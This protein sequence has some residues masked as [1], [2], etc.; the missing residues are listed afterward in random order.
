MNHPE[1]ALLAAYAESPQTL[2]YQEARRH[3]IG[4]PECRGRVSSLQ[5]VI[6]QIQ[7]DPSVGRD[8]EAG[9]HL[10]EVVISDYLEGRPTDRVKIQ[11]HLA[12]CDYCAEGALYYAVESAGGHEAKLPE[13]TTDKET[14]PFRL[15]QNILS[16]RV[17]VWVPAGVLAAMALFAM[18]LTRDEKVI[19][20][21]YQDR[22]E[23]VFTSK[24][25]DIPGMGFFEG[26]RQKSVSYKGLSVHMQDSQNLRIAWP[27]VKTA[28]LYEVR[29]YAWQEGVRTLVGQAGTSGEREV[30]LHL[31]GVVPGRRYEWELSGITEDERRFVARGGIVVGTDH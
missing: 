2:A 25:G 29:F 3:L 27:E 22:P 16:W 7:S 30:L 14:G 11:Q 12:S 26:A 13:K 20:V 21:S 5:S 9:E 28:R 24:K 31:S 8:R 17:P 4:C 19:V 6:R 23:V 18:I 1:V 15:L 10:G